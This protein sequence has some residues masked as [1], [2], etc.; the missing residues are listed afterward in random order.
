M[1]GLWMK[2]DGD[3]FVLTTDENQATRFHNKGYAEAVVEFHFREHIVQSTSTDIS[4]E[5]FPSFG[6]TMAYFGS[7]IFWIILLTLAIYIYG[8]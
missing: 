3:K 2:K 5:M 8:C 4:Q 7:A 6:Q 1:A